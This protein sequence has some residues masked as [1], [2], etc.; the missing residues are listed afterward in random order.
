MLLVATAT[1]ACSANRPPSSVAAKNYDRRC[2]SAADC[3]AVYEG[4]VGCCG[5][6]TC[7]NTAIAQ[8]A[9]S[10]YDVDLGNAASC[11]SGTPPC[12][13]VDFERPCPSARAACDNGVCTFP[14]PPSDAATDE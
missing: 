9:V 13:L 5:E 6:A 2:A 1:A 14:I 3:V 4:Y 11:P 8:D 7:P 12:P 10:K